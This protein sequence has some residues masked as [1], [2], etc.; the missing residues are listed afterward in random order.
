MELDM[1]A[2]LQEVP[3]LG[4]CEHFSPADHIE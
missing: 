2:L 1:I 4:N 3:G